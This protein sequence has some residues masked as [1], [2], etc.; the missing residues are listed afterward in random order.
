MLIY[1]FSLIVQHKMD[2]KKIY[3]RFCKIV[4]ASAV[5]FLTYG[6][7]L[8]LF[9]G[10]TFEL[11]EPIIFIEILEIIIGIV[12]IPYLIKNIFKE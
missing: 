4:G 3:I 6:L 9:F 8:G 11:N 7:I 12:T 10:I 1:R 5:I 2:F